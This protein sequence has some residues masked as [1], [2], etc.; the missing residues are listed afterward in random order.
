MPSVFQINFT[1][2]IHSSYLILRGYINISKLLESCTH[3]FL[4]AIVSAVCSRLFSALLKL[5]RKCLFHRQDPSRAWNKCK[6]L[7]LV[8]VVSVAKWSL[9]MTFYLQVNTEVLDM[10]SVIYSCCFTKHSKHWLYKIAWLEITEVDAFSKLRKGWECQY[11]LFSFLFTDCKVLQNTLHN[12][13][14]CL[15]L[16]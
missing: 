14:N 7:K 2:L 5:I 15:W 13:H 4:H 9:Q 8:S 3:K 12:G 11:G 16:C 10:Q 6:P 1:R